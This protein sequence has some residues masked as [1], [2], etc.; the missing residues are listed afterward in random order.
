V[1]VSQVILLGIAGQKF[2]LRILQLPDYVV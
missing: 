1:L 2:S